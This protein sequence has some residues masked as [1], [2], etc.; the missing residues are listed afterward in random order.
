MWNVDVNTECSSRVA[1]PTNMSI[2]LAN[3]TLQMISRY[4]YLTHKKRIFQIRGSFCSGVRV[5]NVQYV[6]CYLR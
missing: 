4:Y 6:L 1:K 5:R 3:L 2:L